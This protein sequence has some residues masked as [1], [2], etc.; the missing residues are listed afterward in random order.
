VFFP[1]SRDERWLLAPKLHEGQKAVFLLQP[2]R[3]D[4][5]PQGALVL[6]LPSDVQPEPDMDRLRRLMR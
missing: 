5:L 3:G 1:N 2:Y 4:D 6:L